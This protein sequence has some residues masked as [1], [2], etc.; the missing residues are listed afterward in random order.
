MNS[1]YTIAFTLLSVS[2]LLEPSFHDDVRE[3]GQHIKDGEAF[4]YFDHTFFPERLLNPDDYPT[5]V[6][7]EGWVVIP[8]DE[9]IT[10]AE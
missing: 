9:C 1:P 4:T 8:T 7:Y 6:W 10:L 5:S 2:D 3:V